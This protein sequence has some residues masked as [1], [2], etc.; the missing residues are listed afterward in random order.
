M[1]GLLI[2]HLLLHSIQFMIHY[3]KQQK[4]QQKLVLRIQELM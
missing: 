4:K 3:Y 2:V 1:D